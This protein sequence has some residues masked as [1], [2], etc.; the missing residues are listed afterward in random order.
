[1]VDIRT[2][3]EMIKGLLAE[4]AGNQLSG[5]ELGALIAVLSAIVLI[6][7]FRK[8]LSPRTGAARVWIERY[9][10][11]LLL[12]AIVVAFSLYGAVASGRH[13]GY[14]RHLA[15]PFQ[16]E[17]APGYDARNV[18]IVASL[19]GSGVSDATALMEDGRVVVPDLFRREYDVLALRITDGE[20]EFH[21]T[22]FHQDLRSE[23]VGPAHQFPAH[24]R[25]IKKLGSYYFDTARHTLDAQTL[26]EVF[27]TLS[28][29]P[30]DVERLLWFGHADER[31]PDS[32]NFWLGLKR[33]MQVR[34]EAPLGKP[35][36]TDAAHIVASFGEEWPALLGTGPKIETENRRV[37]VFAV[38]RDVP[39]TQPLQG[40]GA[41]N[42]PID[43]KSSVSRRRTRQSTVPQH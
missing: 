16:L 11:H 14:L 30:E 19:R 8:D 6:R 42:K 31:G 18:W 23:I 15:V 29:I 1:M 22:E 2:A 5:R 38:L 4:L 7:Y 34:L 43:A 13:L 12:G 28:V 41:Q 39:T 33:A 27:K 32:A 10:K 17:A 3:L 20:R 35:H 9:Q 40:T 25:R 24:V 21:Y 36:M 26:R 37:T